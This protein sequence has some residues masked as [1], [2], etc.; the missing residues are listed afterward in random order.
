[1]RLVKVKWGKFSLE[2]PGE[3]FL[4]VLV[5]RPR[6][7]MLEC[8]SCFFACELPFDGGFVLVDAL[9]PGVCFRGEA[10]DGWDPALAQALP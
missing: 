10:C 4:L 7:L 5:S 8:L 3:I 9:V 6:D 2:L 1:M